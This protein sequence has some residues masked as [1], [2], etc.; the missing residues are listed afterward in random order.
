[1]VEEIDL[2]KLVIEIDDELIQKGVEP[3]QRPMSA[4]LIIA[5]RLKPDSSAIFENDPLFN[6]VNQIYSELYRSTDLYMPP[7]HVGAFMFR[8]VFFPLHIPRIYGSP[9]INPVD[10]LI[11]VP[12]IKKNGCLMIGKLAWR[13]SI[14]LS[15]LWI[16][17]TD[18]MILEK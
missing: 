5:Q 12:D 1:V 16:L 4:Y 10:F 3:F 13:S 8:D 9:A 18:L 11:D 14:R 2:R 15:I 7:M 17:C 6:A